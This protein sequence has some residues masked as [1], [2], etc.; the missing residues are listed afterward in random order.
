M[1]ISCSVPQHQAGYALLASTR[2]SPSPSTCTSARG[3]TQK[4]HPIAFGLIHLPRNPSLERP[5]FPPSLDPHDP[6]TPGQAPPHHTRKKPRN[7]KQRTISPAT[8]RTQSAISLTSPPRNHSQA[9]SRRNEILPHR[10]HDE[11]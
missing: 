3:S 7:E 5:I 8:Q 11:R 2:Y 4:T 9:R 10:S 6:L 1:P